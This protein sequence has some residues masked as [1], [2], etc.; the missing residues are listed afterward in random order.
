MS[1]AC[2][3]MVNGQAPFP[4]RWSQRGGIPRISGFTL[5]VVDVFF[6]RRK[7]GTRSPNTPPLPF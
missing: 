5:G 7:I 2:L 4:S 1:F 3:E 6:P